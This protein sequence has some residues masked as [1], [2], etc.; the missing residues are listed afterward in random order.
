LRYKSILIISCIFLI[1]E[2]VAFDGE[3]YFSDVLPR[4]QVCSAPPDS[5]MK[6]ALSGLRGLGF[7]G[8][9]IAYATRGGSLDC[10]DGWSRKEFPAK[11]VELNTTFRL[12][13]V[14][15]AI[16][17]LAILDL[18]QRKLIRLDDKLVDLLGMQGDFQDDRIRLITI[19][20]LLLHSAGFDRRISGDPMMSPK[21]WCPRDLQMLKSVRLAFDPGSR[22]VYSNVGYCLLGA[23][24]ARLN[25]APVDEV[26]QR[27]F[28]HPS[29]ASLF[30]VNEDVKGNSEVS[31]YS[32]Q[33]HAL[34]YVDNLDYASLVAV[35]GWGGS[36]SDLNKVLLYLA[37]N[38][39]DRLRSYEGSNC[40]PQELY[41]CHGFVLYFSQRKGRK[42]MYW[43]DGSLPGVTTFVGV[44]SDGSSIV[45]L[46]N[47]R[48]D[49]ERPNSKVIELLYRVFGEE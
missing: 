23:V 11:A 3:W 33:G 25:N 30:M 37:A 15:K 20:E 28:F 5:R 1:I 2:A 12:A 39:T 16:T 21:P 19:R 48:E 45:F 46:G 29:G 9:Q 44:F 31:S 26:F 18:V 4:P 40:M 10:A 22:Y 36:A 47:S 32:A 24:V 42:A 7:P 35:G 38:Y 6:L 8:F 17:S 49:G 34:N 43:R 41:S 27:L 14:S 13:S